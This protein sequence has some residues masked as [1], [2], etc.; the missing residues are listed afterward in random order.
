[1]LSMMTDTFANVIEAIRSTRPLIHHITNSVSINDCA[2]VT[3]A[4]GATPVMAEAPEEVDEMVARA[5][6]LVLNIGTLSR[7]QVDS[8]L[9]AGRAANTCG[10][11]IVLDPVGAGA[12]RFR[13]KSAHRLMDRLDVAVLKGNPGEIGVLAGV[14]GR[15]TGVDSGGLD[16]DPLLVAQEYAA[17]AG[18]TVVVSGTHDVVTDGSRTVVV[19]NGHAMMGALS[20]TG[21]MAASLT[22]AFAAVWPDRVVSSATALAAFGIAGERA[23]QS[24]SGPYSFRTALMDEVTRLRQRD[25]LH[26]ARIRTV[27]VSN[28]L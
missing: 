26:N 17:H 21:C 13:T 20:G 10:I 25:L 23:V 16:G 22:A 14:G 24:A 9:K 18:V 15:V 4:I 19:D 12:T 2:N 28:G 8:M 27:G 1:V 11:P 3:L 5:D 6:A 7:S